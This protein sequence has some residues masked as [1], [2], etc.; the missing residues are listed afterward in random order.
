MKKEKKRHC[1]MFR[2]KLYVQYSTLAPRDA[3]IFCA[4]VVLQALRSSLPTVAA[5]LDSAKGG[6]GRADDPLVDSDHPELQSFSNAEATCDVAGEDV[7]S[8]ALGVVLWCLGWCWGGV[9]VVLGG[10]G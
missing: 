1:C 4:E 8:E 5:F 6:V 3:E 9:G 10:M 2:Y 7:G